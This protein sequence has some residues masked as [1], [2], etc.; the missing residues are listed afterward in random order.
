MFVNE[1]YSDRVIKKRTELMP[2]LKEARRKNQRAFLRFD[3]LVIYDNPANNAYDPNTAYNIFIDK[4]TGLFGT[5]LPFK[6]IKETAKKTEEKKKVFTRK[7]RRLSAADGLN[8]IDKALETFMNYQQE[9]DRRFWEAEEERERREEERDEKRRKED[10]E[11]FL[12]LMQA[13]NK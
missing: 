3:K 4:Y 12:K 13:L 7:K 6:T 11:F 8:K 10:Q 9:A 1:D 5:C 2:K